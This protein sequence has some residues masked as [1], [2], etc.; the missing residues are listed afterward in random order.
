MKYFV[1]IFNMVQEKVKKKKGRWKQ[2]KPQQSYI[3][4]YIIYILFYESSTV[5][6]LLLANNQ[7][8]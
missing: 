5:T 2:L 6:S 1:L 7:K 4:I 3:K 8:T